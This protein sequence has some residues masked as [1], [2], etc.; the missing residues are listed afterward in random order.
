VTESHQPIPAP[1]KEKERLSFH[2]ETPYVKVHRAVINA[3][4][5]YSLLR[6]ISN[7]RPLAILGA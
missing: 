1:I 4:L 5:A 6:D 3:L 2:R 7:E